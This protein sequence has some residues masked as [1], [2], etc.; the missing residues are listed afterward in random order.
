MKRLGGVVWA[1]VATFAVGAEELRL[2]FFPNITHAQ[3]LYAKATGDFEKATGVKIK[4]TAF[5]AGP[6]AIES[7]FANAIDAT[8]IGPSPTING[9]VKSRG[10]EFVIVAGAASGGAGLVVRGDSGINSETDFNGKMIATPQLGNTQ[11][12][13][14]RLWF[15][16]KHYRFKDRGGSLALVPLTSSDQLLMFKKK[17]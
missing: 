7:I 14:A 5:N 15:G 8:Y 16:E 4:W 12:V 10:L 9:Y 3:A 1:L 6:T 2:G 17:E 11:D 13:A